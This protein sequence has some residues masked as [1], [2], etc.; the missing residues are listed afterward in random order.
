NA[1]A[2][3]NWS[4]FGRFAYMAGME[5]GYLGLNK[6]L[7]DYGFDFGMLTLIVA[8]TSLILKTTTF[9]KYGGFPF[10]VLFIYAMPNFMFEE[11]VHIRQ[12]LANAIALYSIRYV[13]DRNLI[14]F[15]ICIT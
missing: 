11:H 6:I 5:K 3:V 1:L 9:Y 15:L 2:Y 12:G 7:V 13:I 10:L 8:T 4:E 14:K